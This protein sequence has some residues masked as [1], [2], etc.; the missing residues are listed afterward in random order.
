VS[1]RTLN[2]GILAHVD[3]GKT[4][5]TER[6]L[7]AAG[8]IDEIGSVDAGTTQTDSLGLER[9]RGI[10]IRA[11]VTSFVLSDV[12]VN[13]I[14]TPGHPDFIAEVERVLSMLDGA[15]LVISAVE[16]VQA[17][18]HILMRALR[19]LR[20]PTVIFVNKVDRR[21]ARDQ[22][23]LAQITDQLTPV[24]TALTSVRDIGTAHASVTFSKGTMCRALRRQIRKAAAY[25]VFFG[26]A[27][28]GAGIAELV[29]GIAG[30]LPASAVSPGPA[31]GAVFKIERGQ[32]GDKVAYLRMFA[33]T[34]AVRDRLGQ[35]KVTGI[36]VFEHGGTAKRASVRAGQIAKVWGL[37]GVRVGDSIGAP[38]RKT[39]QFAPPALEAVAESPGAEGALYAALTLLAEQDP[40]IN[41][42]Q[43]R[44][45]GIRVSLYGDV[46]KQVLQRTL[47]DDFGLKVRFRETVVRCIERPAA[48]GTAVRRIKAD[49]NPFLATVGLRVDPAP[50]DSGVSFGLEI[51][52]GALPL[53]FIKAVEDTVR[54]TLS[55]GLNGWPVTDCV[56]TL[57]ESGYCPRQSHSH[58]GFSKSMSS[59]GAD[60][61]G[62]TPVVLLAALRH[63]GTVV[64]APVQ[65][66]HLSVPA[67]VAPAVMTVLTRLDGIPDQQ[68][69]TA[70]TCVTEGLIPAASVRE[71]TQRLPGLT[72][73]QGVLE[74]RFDHYERWAASRVSAVSV[75]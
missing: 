24:A 60:F 44:G 33:G 67:D 3:A 14:D 55:E 34:L 19:R 37:T 47:A 20:I 29:D 35:G 21:G 2:L 27:I 12:S 68:L 17:Q 36:S 4:S 51:E 28:T 42:R 11:A 56:V 74:V 70:R 46:Q 15:V 61:R 10:T 13:L 50:P 9:E 8:A 6:L 57:T 7:Y 66:F 52:L 30:L 45:G 25:P 71:L 54:L 62:V 40:L 43:D 69:M 64:C 32:A 58:Q 75:R 38:A 39:H 53:A 59:T 1:D 49:S 65:R 16:G 5:L 31:A 22:E 72:G 63:G 26:S 73:G 23:L 18:T 48:T 41:V